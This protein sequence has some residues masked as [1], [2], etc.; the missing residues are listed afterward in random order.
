MIPLYKYWQERRGVLDLG[1]YLLNTRERRIARQVHSARM[2]R[3]A[4]RHDVRNDPVMR[5]AGVGHG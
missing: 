5:Q 1:P 2:K 3:A 4:K